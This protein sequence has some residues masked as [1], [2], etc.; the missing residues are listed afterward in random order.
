MSS[1]CVTRH[2]LAWGEDEV[3]VDDGRLRVK[4]VRWLP[5]GEYS[6]AVPITWSERPVV[7]ARDG[8]LEISP[9]L[10]PSLD[11]P[12]SARAIPF[13]QLDLREADGRYAPID[14]CTTEF[15]LCIERRGHRL[16][17]IHVLGGDHVRERWVRIG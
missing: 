11:P 10:D 14:E 3:T 15:A 16:F 5:D 1:S 2:A 13:R 8:L 17:R 12:F 7:E 6:I 4:N 9:P